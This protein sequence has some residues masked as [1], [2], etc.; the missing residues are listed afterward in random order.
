L[1]YRRLHTEE[2]ESLREDF[3]Q[4][5][6][7]NSITA[8]DWTQIKSVQPEKADQLLDI[9]SDLVW[10][11]VLE[12]ITHLEFRSP[13][14]LTLIKFDD[15]QAEMVNI[16]IE[17]QNLDFSNANDLKE[18][19]EGRIKLKSLKPQI[20]KGKKKHNKLREMEVFYYLEQGGKPCSEELWNSSFI[21]ALLKAESEKT[22]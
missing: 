4:F 2:L 21:Q 20:T 18:I 17:D 16:K 8:E 12:K 13:K 5:L 3:V 6:A 14:Q 22:T 9:F 19:A 11:K 7:A 10:E 15:D 1:K